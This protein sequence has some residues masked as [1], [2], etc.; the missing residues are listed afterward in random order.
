MERRRRIVV[1]PILIIVLGAIAFVFLPVVNVTFGNPRFNGV[2]QTY[3]ASESYVL[4]CAGTE[5]ISPAE[6]YIW[7]ECTSVPGVYG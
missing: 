4:L 3:Y 1:I 7:V 2:P 5:Y 6:S